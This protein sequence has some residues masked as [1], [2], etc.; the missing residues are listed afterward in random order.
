[1][2][3]VPFQYCTT[4]VTKRKVNLKNG[5]VQIS[6]EKWLDL[7][8]AVFYTHMRIAVNEMHY[9]KNV[10]VALADE[11]IK[12]IIASVCDDDYVK[13]ASGVVLLSHIDREST[14]FPLCMQNLQSILKKKHRLAHEERFYITF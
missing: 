6:C 11:R 2:V 4:L 1:M 7:M 12:N 8:L 14:F 13:L 3:L 10:Q 5:Y 9:S